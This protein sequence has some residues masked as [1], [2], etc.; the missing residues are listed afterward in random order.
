[1]NKI[2]DRIEE[3][4]KSKGIG[5]Y[6]DME[7]RYLNSIDILIYCAYNLIKQIFKTYI[8]KE[9]ESLHKFTDSFIINFKRIL[10]KEKNFKN[11]MRLTESQYFKI[12]KL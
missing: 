3:Y 12:E 10:N 6:E 11:D 9:K 4:I 1:V 5:Y 2:A 7:N 8:Y